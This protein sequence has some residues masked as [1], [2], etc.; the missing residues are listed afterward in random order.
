MQYTHSFYPSYFFSGSCVLN[1][2]KEKAMFV[3]RALRDVLPITETRDLTLEIHSVHLNC[4]CDL[5]R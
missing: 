2:M 3:L 5:K 1:E 4:A